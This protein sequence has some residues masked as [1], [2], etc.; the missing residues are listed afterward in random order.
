MATGRLAQHYLRCIA[1][2][3][4]PAVRTGIPGLARLQ[5]AHGRRKEVPRMVIV[6]FVGGS[7]WQ[8]IIF[9][10][11]FLAFQRPHWQRQACLQMGVSIQPWK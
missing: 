2:F 10:G 11:R 8:P 9:I 1:G 3:A 4:G 5:G 6:P 7:S